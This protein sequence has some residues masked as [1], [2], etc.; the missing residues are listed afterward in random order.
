MHKKFVIEKWAHC[1]NF[2]I[3]QKHLQKIGLTG[4][5]ISV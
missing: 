5:L 3:D 2:F 1:C 4:E